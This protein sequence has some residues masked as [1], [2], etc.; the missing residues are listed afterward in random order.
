MIAALLPRVTTPQLVPME[1]INIM[2]SKLSRLTYSSAELQAMAA[3]AIAKGQI[4]AAIALA[5][6]AKDTEEEEE[7]NRGGG[8]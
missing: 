1:G 4:E 6:N 7:D 2:S 3:E 5:Q 8:R